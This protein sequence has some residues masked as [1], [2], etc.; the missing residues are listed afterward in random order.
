[1][2]VLKFL[3]CGLLLAL[4][5]LA[6]ESDDRQT[7]TSLRYVS[8]ELDTRQDKLTTGSN[9]ALTYTNAAGNV[10]Q[11]TVKSDLTGGTTD[12][13]LP[14]AEAV[15]A[16]L[17]TKQ[18]DI[19]TID[20][21]T[22]VTYTGQ[23]GTIGQKGI[24]QD[25]GTYDDQSDNLIDAKTFNAALKTGL[26]N[27]FRCRD[28]DPNTNLCWVYSIHNTYEESAQPYVSATGTV[29]QDG[30]PTPTN[31]VYPKF[32][33]QGDMILRRVG[34]YADSFDAATHKITRR[35]GVKVLNGT[36]SWEYSSDWSTLYPTFRLIDATMNDLG[37]SYILPAVVYC[38]NFLPAPIN[39]GYSTPME[40][41]T[42]SVG[43]PAHS[44]HTLW[45]RT[46]SYTTVADFK[47]WLAAQY[48]AGT[49]VMIYY[50]LKTPVEEDWTET[51]YNENVY[52]PQNQ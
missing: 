49:P 37:T 22:A 51:T 52:I 25:T 33:Q 46:N 36:E 23:V 48:V 44:S 28:W 20:D 14:M 2:K 7:A 35:V 26:D 15:N 10:E 32:F 3:L 38:S 24:Y 43:S 50:P 8:H 29:T 16:G 13:S 45:I 21:H 11:R 18:D 30:T 12:T 4:P 9:K 17:N 27:E 6:E 1:M 41:N 19:A 5:V 40:N 31:P 34:D 42:I 39:N 47:R